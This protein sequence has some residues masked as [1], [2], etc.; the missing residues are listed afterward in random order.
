MDWRYISSQHGQGHLGSNPSGNVPIMKWGAPG[1]TAVE[2]CRLVVLS[3]T[4]TER[5]TYNDVLRDLLKLPKIR[6]DI[7]AEELVKARAQIW[8]TGGVSFPPGT[9][10]RASYKGKVYVAHVKDGA[11]MVNGRKAPNP[12][13][14]ANLITG[15]NVNGW[16]FWE[17]RLPGQSDWRRLENY[18]R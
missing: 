6:P 2:A 1:R 10:F 18:R 14:A 13:A 17:A 9:E 3:R 15:T 7:G 4:P 8:S 11:L 5:D 12:S 16:R